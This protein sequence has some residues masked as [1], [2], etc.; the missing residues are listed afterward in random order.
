MYLSS[1]AV[2][3][4]YGENFRL[5]KNALARALRFNHHF[6][7]IK[8]E[9]GLNIL[10]WIQDSKKKQMGDEGMDWESGV[11]RCKLLYIE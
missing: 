10:M 5:D 9:T 11:S 7:L 1:S 4:R 2:Y 8:L 6:A 3:F